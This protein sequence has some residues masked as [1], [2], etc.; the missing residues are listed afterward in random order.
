MSPSTNE[1]NLK[2]PTYGSVMFVHKGKPVLGPF[3]FIVGDIK[4]F[5]QVYLP[6]DVSLA[7]TFHNN[8][9]TNEPVH[10]FKH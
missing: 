7:Q 4:G 3:M 10:T 5:R 8:W 1:N 2:H 6:T 9:K